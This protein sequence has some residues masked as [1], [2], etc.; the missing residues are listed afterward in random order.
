LKQKKQRSEIGG[1]YVKFQ[2]SSGGGGADD[3]GSILA[4][5]SEQKLVGRVDRLVPA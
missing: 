1:C 4:E 5:H 2:F 3:D